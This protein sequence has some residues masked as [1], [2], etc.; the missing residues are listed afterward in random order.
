MFRIRA[1]VEIWKHDNSPSESMNG[2]EILDWLKEEQNL[3][4]KLTPWS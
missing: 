1:S 2:E 3:K 4:K